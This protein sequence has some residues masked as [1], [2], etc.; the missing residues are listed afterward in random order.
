MLN[1]KSTSSN[2]YFLTKENLYIMST[3]MDKQISFTHS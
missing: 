2:V 3:K 1:N